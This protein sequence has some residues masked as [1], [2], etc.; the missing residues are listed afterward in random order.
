M[1]AVHRILMLVKAMSSVLV[2]HLV[3]TNSSQLS[4]QARET[5]E[6]QAQWLD[7]QHDFTIKGHAVS[8][9][10][11]AASAERYSP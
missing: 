1:T 3:D 11:A 2:C 5:L 8:A 4:E 10:A 6:R 9:G 7:S